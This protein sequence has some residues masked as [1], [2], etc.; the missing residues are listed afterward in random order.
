[1]RA[2]LTRVSQNAKTGPIPVSITEPASCPRG[3]PI[4]EKGCYALAFPLGLHW[5]RVALTGATW[6][7]FIREINTLI[8]GQLWRH[9]QAGDLP[10]DGHEID[11]EALGELVDVNERRDLRGFTYTHYPIGHSGVAARNLLAIRDANA[12]GFVIN[13]STNNQAEAAVVRREYPDLP[14]VTILPIDGGED[15]G[16][17][18]TCPNH[19]DKRIQCDRCELCSV[20]DRDFVIGF[21][22]H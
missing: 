22:A 16:D 10:G 7:Q 11:A 12:R 21:P 18:V 9:N 15:A 17:V 20:V 19:V 5:R 4:R 13:I 3:C 8:A 2:N 14:V 1:M 6:A